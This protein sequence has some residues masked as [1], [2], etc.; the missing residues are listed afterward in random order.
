MIAYFLHYHPA[1]KQIGI[2]KGKLSRVFDHYRKVYQSSTTS[3]WSALLAALDSGDIEY[4]VINRLLTVDSAC[5]LITAWRCVD[6][7]EIEVINYLQEKGFDARLGN[8]VLKIWGS[9]AKEYL[10]KNPYYMLAFATWKTVDGI[11]QRNYSISPDDPRRLIGAVLACLYQRLIK[12][13]HTITSHNELLALLEGRLGKKHARLSSESIRMALTKQVIVGDEEGGYQTAGAELLERRVK[14]WVEGIRDSRTNQQRIS[15]EFI[16]KIISKHEGAN[17]WVLTVEQREA[18]RMALTEPVSVLCGGAGCGKTTVLKV[19][20]DAVEGTGSTFYQMALSG[21]AATRMSYATSKEACT[22]AGFIYKAKSGALNLTG[23]PFIVIDEASMLDLPTMSKI[24][25]CLRNNPARILMV[26]DQHQLPPIQFGL[27]FHRLVESERI[28]K[29]ELTVVKRATEDSGIPAVATAIRNRQVP[30]LLKYPHKAEQGVSFLTCPE[31]RINYA[32]REVVD[33]IGGIEN[34]QV[35]SI[36]KQRSGGTGEINSMFQAQVDRTYEARGMG[37]R[38]TLYLD[39]KGGSIF[40]GERFSVGDKVLYT[41][42]DPERGL[43]NGSLG[44]VREVIGDALRCD[45]DGVEYM[46]AE[47]DIRRMELSYSITVHKA[48]GSQFKRIVIPIVTSEN[49]LDRSMV[50]TAA[51]RGEEQVVFVGNDR[52]FERA[53]LSEAHAESRQVGLQV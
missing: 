8:K 49:L 34:V 14:L 7:T 47:N 28:C 35:L 40:P 45:Y 22:I 20:S 26:G 32:V 38:P 52:A 25:Q 27:V 46:M 30:K 36:R 21:R 50:Y 10:D 33:D 12:G 4:F 23:Y 13:K 48:Q 41:H 2:G 43:N 31:N 16:E 51:T 39:G 17:G 42:N 1:F 24:I 5:R 53:I 11:A 6:T 44:V 9:K 37:E 29:T 18:V 3:W 15:D 19:I